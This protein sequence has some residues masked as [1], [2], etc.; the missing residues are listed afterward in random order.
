MVEFTTKYPNQITLLCLGP[1]TN[2][3]T[4]FNQNNAIV[5]NFKRIFAI[6]GDRAEKTEFNVTEYSEFNFYSDP[7]AVEIV[8]K[9]FGKDPAYPFYL[10]DWMT[11]L[12][13]PI[14]GEFF[15]GISD[16]LEKKGKHTQAKIFWARPPK[17][18]D[19][20]I[21]RKDIKLF[22]ADEFPTAVSCDESMIK[23]RIRVMLETIDKESDKRGHTIFSTR[24]D[25]NIIMVDEL[26]FEKF[27]SSY[28]EFMNKQAW[29]KYIHHWAILNFHL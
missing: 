8:L 9:N 29:A 18:L 20:N 12:K 15:D 4:A 10:V 2:L 3:A 1:L 6:G 14:Y 21:P 24:E 5:E 17:L 28:L 13:Y 27:K 16:M 26:D 7:Q 23:H 22:I 19:P 11:C 25:G